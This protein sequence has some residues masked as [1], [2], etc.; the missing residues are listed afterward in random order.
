MID[1]CIR[2]VGEPQVKRCLDSA[3]NQV[4]SFAN[5][6]HVDGIVPE[7]EA[8]RALL[9][10]VKSEWMMLIDGDMILY[11]NAVKIAQDYIGRETDSSVVE[12]QFGLYDEFIKRVINSCR[13][14][15]V[16]AIKSVQTRDWIGNDLNIVGQ[17]EKTGKK[18]L[19]LWKG[20]NPVVIGTHF[21]NPDEFQIFVRYYHAGVLRTSRT[22]ELLLDLYESTKDSRY[23]FAMKA[24][25]YGLNKRYKEYP[26]SRD[27]NYDKKEFENFSCKIFINTACPGISINDSEIVNPED[28]ISYL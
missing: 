20:S 2:S 23:A 13:V 1:A 12:Y 25:S 28:I 15:K 17:M 16:D 4:P 6:I 3:I 7:V 18:C 27:V 10:Q 22:M 14:S 11:E 19:R 24:L 5:V 26:G 8:L 9:N 21:E